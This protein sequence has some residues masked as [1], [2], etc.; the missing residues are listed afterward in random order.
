LRTYFVN[1]EQGTKPSIM[2][3]Q[4]I[5]VRFSFGLLTLALGCIS[6]ATIPRSEGDKTV[7]AVEE[8][9]PRRKEKRLPP[10][11]PP[12]C[13]DFR[14]EDVKRIAVLPQVLQSPGGMDYHGLISGEF[15]QALVNKGYTVVSRDLGPIVKE[16][17]QGGNVFFNSQTA[18]QVG[19][20][21]GASHVMLI[22]V[23]IF[24]PNEAS[25]SITISSQIVEVET[26][27]VKCAFTEK[28]LGKPFYRGYG[29]EFVPPTPA[30]PP[31][32][33]QEMVTK[34]AERLP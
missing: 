21:A 28:K 12:A 17:S 24:W 6:C 23:P 26:G 5:A 22:T 9:K 4:T 8:E 32:E 13:P 3:K 27:I 20:L 7:A 18:V 31:A 29:G 25:C 11:P 30:N 1:I 33:L 16:I 15:T 34:A 2:K 19:K 10:P 14:R